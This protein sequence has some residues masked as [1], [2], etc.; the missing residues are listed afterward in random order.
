VHRRTVQKQWEAG[1]AGK[2][3]LPDGNA[4]FDLLTH[5]VGSDDDR[6]TLSE[7]E[8]QAEQDVQF[9]AATAATIGPTSDSKAC[10]LF[11]HEQRLLDQMTELAES[12]RSL[13]DARIRKLVEWIRSNMCPELGKPG[14]KW[15]DTR[16]I[17][18]TEYDDT[19][20]YLQQ[21]LEAAISKSDRADDRI[22]V[23][24]G[25]TPPAKREEIKTAFN[26]DPRKHTVRILIATD[27]A[28]EGLNLQAHC[29]NLFH[30]D[31]PWNPSR[32]EQRNGRIDRKLQPSPAVFCHY[33]VYQQ[34]PEDRIIQVLVRK[35]ETIREELGSLSQVI[36][37]K[38][39]KTMS[40]GIRRKDI[41]RLETEI[42]S[43]NLESENRRTVEQELEA[44]RERQDL[45]REQ[46]DRLRTLLETCGWRIPKLAQ[47][48]RL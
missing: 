2:K 38:L 24:H 27:A 25:P 32:M 44:S 47:N 8:L 34:R 39:A 45:L 11:G 37:S 1:A 9:E 20:R 3:Q 48:S 29:W 28:R 26:A 46:I 10:E 19:K 40:Q 21:Q 12:T 5:S 30:F 41:G 35:T 14:S 18:F 15:N 23:Y 42:Q 17:I 7:E 43:A 6:A 31:V 33:F 22:L 36:D 4:S 13:P 16:C